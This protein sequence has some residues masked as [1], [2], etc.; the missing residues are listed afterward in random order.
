MDVW[1]L[2]SEFGSLWLKVCATVWGITS[3]EGHDD[4]V[5]ADRSPFQLTPFSVILCVYS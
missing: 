4:R 1:K 2:N 5:W 3:A